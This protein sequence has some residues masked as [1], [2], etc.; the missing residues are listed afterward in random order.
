MRVRQL[1][2]ILPER[3]VSHFDA[4]AANFAEAVTALEL[5]SDA[6][7]CR[8]HTRL[9]KFINLPEL[10]S[11]FRSVADVQTAGMLNLPRPALATGK[12]QVVAAPA[13]ESLKAYIK[14]LIGRAERLRSSRVDNM[15]KITGDARK[16]IPRSQFVV[17]QAFRPSCSDRGTGFQPVISGVF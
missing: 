11:M 7:G 16:A 2:R 8:M 9:A 5:A 6:A 14:T 12:P 3:G 17:E 4:W 1:G 10:L 13:R 15:C